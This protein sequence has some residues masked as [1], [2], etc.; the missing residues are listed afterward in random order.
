MCSG[1]SDPGSLFGPP[2]AP[3]LLRSDEL[4]A[5]GLELSAHRAAC[6]LPP[7]PPCPPIL[8]EPVLGPAPPELTLPELTPP[9][10]APTKT[11]ST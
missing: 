4:E 10:V 3:L 9:A 11:D 8:D 7:L 1:V 5:Q 2:F 6:C